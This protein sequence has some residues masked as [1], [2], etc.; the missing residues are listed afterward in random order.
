M[1][2]ARVM[3]AVPAKAFSPRA[4][5]NRVRSSPISARIR[6]LSTVPRPGKLVMIWASGCW[7]NAV[8]SDSPGGHR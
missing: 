6:A 2:L 5:A 8:V 4:V 1:A 7:P 3:G